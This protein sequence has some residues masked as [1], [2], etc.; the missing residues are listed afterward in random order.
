MD[1]LE[2]LCTRTSVS[3]LAE[4]GPTDA[5]FETMLR[6]ASRAPDHGRMRPWRFIVVRGD[7]RARLGEVMAEAL[8]LAEPA[9]SAALLER[10]R[11]KPLR[12]PAILVVA[13]TL[14]P[15]PGVPEIEQIIAGGA[16][17]QNIL[18]A[19]HALGLGAIWRTGERAYDEPV[20]RALGLP[21]NGAV[22]GFIYL[23][24]PAPDVRPKPA[25]H[26]VDTVEWHGPSGAAA[27]P[28]APR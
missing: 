18:L 9:A 4:P 5:Q 12:A 11:R 27:P 7:A 21:P 6:A 10:E 26:P 14:Q 8:R 2:A 1:A 13:V 22:I 16:A 28:A 17:A 20:K 24:T 23:G 3:S 25:G 15:R 19:A